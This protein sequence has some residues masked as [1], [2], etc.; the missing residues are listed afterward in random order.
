MSQRTVTIEQARAMA[1]PK[2][3]KP[4]ARLTQQ[5]KLFAKRKL[6]AGADPIKEMRKS[7]KRNLTDGFLVLWEQKDRL[8]PVRELRFHPVRKWRFDLAWP[9]ARVAV[10]FDG[11]IF[12]GGGHTR[13]ILFTDNA[14]KQNAAVMLGWHLLRYTTLDLRQRPLQIIEEIEEALKKWLI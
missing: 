11:G 4:R 1:K 10:E 8:E 6:P 9:L 12:T 2:K 5:G 7:G 3:K 13:G 14:A